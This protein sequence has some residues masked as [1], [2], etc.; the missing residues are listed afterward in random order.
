MHKSV[1]LC[2]LLEIDFLG[3]DG[4]PKWLQFPES[5]PEELSD[6]NDLNMTLAYAPW[7]LSSLSIK[8]MIELWNYSSLTTALMIIINF[9]KLALIHES[10]YC[11]I[12]L[13]D[14][15]ICDFQSDEEVWSKY[16]KQLFEFKS[17]N[18]KTDAFLNL[19]DFSWEDQG[20]YILNELDEDNVRNLNEEIEFIDELTSG[21]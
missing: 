18:E 5:V 4:D 6:L 7:N 12:L 14:Q 15:E 9:H 19:I 10:A 11:T 2:H 3:H 13:N 20:K 17:F 1:V 8:Q 21:T 16:W